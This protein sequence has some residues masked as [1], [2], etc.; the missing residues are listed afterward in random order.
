MKEE[1]IEYITA[2]L[3]DAV[4]KGKTGDYSVFVDLPTGERGVI[5]VILTNLRT[6]VKP[7]EKIRPTETVV[8]KDELKTV[9]EALERWKNN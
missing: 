4:F 3:A 9:C 1:D 7:T 2:E 6:P 8:T 5:T